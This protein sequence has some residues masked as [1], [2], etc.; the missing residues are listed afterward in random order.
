MKNLFRFLFPLACF[1]NVALA[2]STLWQCE[3]QTTG[4]GS[5]TQLVNVTQPLVMIYVDFADGRLAN[6]NAPTA[7]AGAMSY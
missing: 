1:V 2:Q 4:V 5:E 6:G 3:M 7:D